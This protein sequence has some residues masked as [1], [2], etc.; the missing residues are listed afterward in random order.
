MSITRFVQACNERWRTEAGRDDPP[1]TVVGR[2]VMARFGDVELASAFD[3]IHFA[4]APALTA[5]YIA[6]LRSEVSHPLSVSTG[7][8]PEFDA[9]ATQIV[10]FDRLCRTLHL[11]NYLARKRDTYS[12]LV[13][14]VD[15]RHILS[16]PRD[17][18]AYFSELL[19]QCGL[20]AERI[21]LST[22]L[23]LA[24]RSGDYLHRLGQGLANYRSRGYQI[25]VKLDE[26]PMSKATTHFFFRV[27]PDYLRADSRW[28]AGSARALPSGVG[29][30]L[31]LLHRLMFGFGGKVILEHLADEEG[32]ALARDGGIE[33]IQGPFLER[34]CRQRRTA[35]ARR[36]FPKRAEGSYVQAI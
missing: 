13:L 24:A 14:D 30:Y 8:R 28:F 29:R 4:E 15:P 36:R 35:V 9:D 19:E 26:L 2:R 6:R 5:G 7:R 10:N 12:Q 11:L 3:P 33:L 32:L 1:L 16:V 17:H 21:V 27:A 34:P 22:S 20:G 31:G 18:G 23:E 25:A